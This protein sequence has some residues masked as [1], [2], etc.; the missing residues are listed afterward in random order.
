MIKINAAARLS[1]LKLNTVL[2]EQ[3]SKLM[4]PLDQDLT[5]M[6]RSALHRIG[7]SAKP[8][9]VNAGGVKAAVATIQKPRCCG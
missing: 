8:T 4:L 2:P 7:V 9:L 5:I 6:L 3:T 1:F